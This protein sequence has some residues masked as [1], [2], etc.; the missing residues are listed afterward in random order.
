MLMLLSFLALAPVA[1]L[2]GMKISVPRAPSEMLARNMGACGALHTVPD[3]G[4][5][6]GGCG[7]D[8]DGGGDGGSGGG[9]SARAKTIALNKQLTCQT[10][11]V[12]ALFEASGVDFNEVNI[13][14]AI[15]QIAKRQ[16]RRARDPRLR[17]LVS[18][19]ASRVADGASSDRASSPTRRGASP[20]WAS[21]R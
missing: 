1:A 20:H 15:H 21:M 13:A 19:A 9:G 5:D 2:N 10:T 16:D 12:L 6:D 17:K 3:G 14:T 4:G 8:G 18:A 7:G 11:D